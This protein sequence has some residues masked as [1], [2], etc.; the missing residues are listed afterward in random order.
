MD[1]AARGLG[2]LVLQRRHCRAPAGASDC[3]CGVASDHWSRHGALQR[4]HAGT[5]LAS[6][7]AAPFHQ[8]RSKFVSEQLSATQAAATMRAPTDKLHCQLHQQVRLPSSKADAFKVEKD[9]GTSC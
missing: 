9:R 2:C 7:P 1:L 6:L 5:S 8:S 4:V 3:T